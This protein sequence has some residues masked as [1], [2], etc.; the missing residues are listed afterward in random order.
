MPIPRA[1]TTRS[2][3][4]TLFAVA[5]ASGG[6]TGGGPSNAQTPTATSTPN[7]DPNADPELQADPSLAAAAPVAALSLE[8]S[9]PKWAYDHNWEDKP[10]H[11]TELL[12]L[13]AEA[14]QRVLGVDKIIEDAS[15]TCVELSPIPRDE[16]GRPAWRNGNSLGSFIG[17]EN[18]AALEHFHESLERLATGRDDKVRILAYGASHTQGD[19]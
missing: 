17:I 13:R 7:S 1:A 14:Q 2:L 11:N 10:V 16:R 9:G 3:F 19:L 15:G 8:P 18:E 6:L 12:R 5:C 4:A